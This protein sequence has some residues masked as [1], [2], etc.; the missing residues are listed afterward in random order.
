MDIDSSHPDGTPRAARSRRTLALVLPSLIAGA[1]LGGGGTYLISHNY[2]HATAIAPVPAAEPA[3]K[4]PLYQCP[5]HPSITSD[6]PGDCPI[7]G[8][9]LVLV[10]PSEPNEATGAENA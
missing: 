4:K 7:C 3:K 1:V 9:K 5:M 2:D 6:H 8:M 10:R